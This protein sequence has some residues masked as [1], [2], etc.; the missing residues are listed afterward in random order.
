MT[1]SIVDWP[2]AD[3]SMERRAGLKR[4]LLAELTRRNRRQH[5]VRFVTGAAVATTAVS[6][7]VAMVLSSPP[8]ATA[9]WNAVPSPLTMSSHDP[10][11]Q[12]C[13]ADLPKGSPSQLGRAELAPVVA[14]SRGK[15]R[16]VLLGG[17]DSQGVCVA[18]PTTRT[19]GRTLAPPLKGHDISVAGNGGSTDGSGFRYVYGRVSARVASVAVVTTSGVHVTSSVAHGG[20]IAWWP[21]AEGPAR[22][23]AENA[24]GDVI[25]T[26]NPKP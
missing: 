21:G 1:N 20:Y 7:T 6:A 11:V 8:T 25:A 19:G 9:A 17:D 24:N 12:Q 23:V 15:S 2:V 22:I 26:N 3:L 5:R 10:M 4:T 18:T 16:A 13:L 14:E